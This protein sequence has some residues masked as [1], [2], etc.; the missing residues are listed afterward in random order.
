M[1]TVDPSQKKVVWLLMA[2]LIGAVCV[3]AIRVRPSRVSVAAVENRP[4]E[5]T[6]A[7][8]R[9]AVQVQDLTR[10]PFRAPEPYAMA[11][12]RTNAAELG[13]PMPGADEKRASAGK[14]PSVQP[15]V[16]SAVR[17]GGET[18]ESQAGGADLDAKPAFALLATIQSSEGSSAVIKSNDSIV[19]VVNVGDVMEGG[20][21]VRAL[22]PDCAVLSN[23]E[24]T[25][26]V[27]KPQS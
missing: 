19:R 10:N 20:Y 16:V 21:K 14:L 2:I 26:V 25:I 22:K 13:L 8:P 24:D 12:M 18:G 9:V 5:A 4:V 15:L 1:L 7:S 17:R 11:Q 23:G 6:P 3:T 27:K